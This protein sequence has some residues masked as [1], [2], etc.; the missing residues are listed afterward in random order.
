MNKRVVS[1]VVS[2]SVL[3][4]CLVVQSRAESG[5]A[6]RW[7][8]GVAGGYIGH[9]GDEPLKDGALGA[10][11]VGYGLS[12]H[13]TI[14]GVLE[15]CPELKT[16]YRTDWETGERIS[17]LSEASG[18]DLAETSAIRLSVD[19]LLQ[20]AP[21]ARVA[22]Y[23]AAGLGVA[24]YE[25]DF[26]RRVEPVAR[27]GAGVFVNLDPN[28][29]LRFDGRAAVTGEDSEFNLIATAGLVF[30]LGGHRGGSMASDPA[31]SAAASGLAAPVAEPVAEAAPVVRLFVLNLN[32]EPGAWDI[33]AEYRSELDVIG[34][35]LDTRPGATAR[36]EGHDRPGAV[37][38]EGEARALSEKRA[39]A[40]RDYLEANWGVPPSRMQT[41]GFG[42]SRPG[43]DPALS[44]ERIEV[45][46]TFP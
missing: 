16:S 9:E 11:S 10:L 46:V 40:V 37:A 41:H 21:D 36:I 5:N 20:L 29:A 35:L 34:R 28:W 3:A 24:V 12:R 8:I 25:N 17:R 2:L 33:K 45:Y 23:L 39:G 15:V 7:H 43:G 27:A 38:D 26:D 6:G 19:A 42:T 18:R 1:G 31:P 13:W 14:E 30:R 4:G 44:G 32:F 22:P